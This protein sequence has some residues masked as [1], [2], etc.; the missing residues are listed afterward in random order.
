MVDQPFVAKNRRGLLAGACNQ[1]GCE[2]VL[3][4]YSEVFDGTVD[5][6]YNYD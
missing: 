6:K 2:Q 4:T 1:C 3:F 5:K